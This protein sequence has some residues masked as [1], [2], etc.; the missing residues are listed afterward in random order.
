MEEVLKKQREEV[1]E[2]LDDQFSIHTLMDTTIVKPIIEPPSL[3]RKIKKIISFIHEERLSPF[4]EDKLFKNHLAIEITQDLFFL[5]FQREYEPFA[6]S[7]QRKKAIMNPNEQSQ[8]IKFIQA[9]NCKVINHIREEIF[10]IAQKEDLPI[11]VLDKIQP[12]DLLLVFLTHQLE[13]SN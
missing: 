2:W 7:E 12:Q 11:F 6:P 3:H 5:K 1:L 10:Q 9:L 4:L 13:N 8:M